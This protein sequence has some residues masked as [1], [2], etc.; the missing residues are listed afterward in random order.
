MDDSLGH[1]TLFAKYPK[2]RATIS[3]A[4]RRGP[5]WQAARRR[6]GMVT[7]TRSD[8]FDSVG[9]KRYELRPWMEFEHHLH[10]FHKRSLERYLGHDRSTR[11]AVRELREPKASVL[12][13]IRTAVRGGPSA[14]RS[15]SRRGRRGTRALRW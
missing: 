6:Q 4:S 11:F 1:R 9:G 14:S 10:H 12:L 2:H 8:R 3:V 5:S 7:S 15:G 13:G